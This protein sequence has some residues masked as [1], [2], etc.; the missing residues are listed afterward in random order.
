MHG[1]KFDVLSW[2][3]DFLNY[4][5]HYM[6]RVS[7]N[8]GKKHNMRDYSI[9]SVVE[10]MEYLSICIENKWFVLLIMNDPQIFKLYLLS[11]H[12]RWRLLWFYSSFFPFCLHDFNMKF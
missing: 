8:I 7:L 6:L 5:I 10:T 3:N 11:I 1:K 2:K 12:H 9:E 4:I